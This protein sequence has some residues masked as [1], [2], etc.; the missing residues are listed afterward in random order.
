MTTRRTARAAFTLI[1]LLVV[2]AIIGV[3][4]ALLLPAL[5]K[6][7]GTGARTRAFS[8]VSQLSL[9]VQSF[10]NE[11][12]FIP[13]TSFRIPAT[14]QT[15]PTSAGHPDYPGCEIFTRMFPRCLTGIAEGG[16][17]NFPGGGTTLVGS[18]VLV[19]F[20][21]GPNYYFPDTVTPRRSGWAVDAPFAPTQTATSMKGPYYDFPQNRL[22]DPVT[23]VADFVGF[24]DPWENPYVYFGSTT[25]GRYP[26]IPVG[27][28]SP[29]YQGTKPVNEGGC[30]ILSAGANK[31]FGPGGLWVPGTGV[32]VGTESIGG[33]DV[34]NF[35]EGKMLGV[36]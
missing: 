22:V 27:P 23:K 35:N 7:R 15:L 36:N 13:P 18:A 26:P 34:A 29:Y 14:K 5:N 10:K 19:Y 17:T 20:L 6:I 25:G 3:L 24:R 8:E 21:Y 4:M 16:A 33:D 30:Q 31:V 2:I 11:Y 32:Y 1:E 9:A 12:K 28:V